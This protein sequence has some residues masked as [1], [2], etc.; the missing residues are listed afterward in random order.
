[1]GHGNE[2]VTAPT[3][4]DLVT[5]YQ[6]LGI[7]NLLGASGKRTAFGSGGHRGEEIVFHVVRG[8]WSDNEFR[9]LM[10]LAMFGITPEAL[11]IPASRAR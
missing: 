11:L 6:L 8:R 10:E 5:A 1:M 9:G 4:V 3:W 7:D 2:H